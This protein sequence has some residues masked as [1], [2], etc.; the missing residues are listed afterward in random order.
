MLLWFVTLCT[1]AI[2]TY[3]ISGL[4][5]IRYCNTCMGYSRWYIWVPFGARE[6]AVCEAS[7]E[8]QPLGISSLLLWII[9]AVEW[10]CAVIGWILYVTIS[11]RY[12]IVPNIFLFI[13]GFCYMLLYVIHSVYIYCVATASSKHGIVWTVLHVLFGFIADPFVYYY[14]A[15]DIEQNA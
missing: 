15:G 6:L 2:T 7:E 3:I 13:S 5:A 1:P 4:T 11:Y 8:I 14:I 12:R 9:C 10:L